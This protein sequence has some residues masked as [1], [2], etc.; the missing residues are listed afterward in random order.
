MGTKTTHLCDFFSRLVQCVEPHTHE[1]PG[2]HDV[3]G[4]DADGFY[5]VA[6]E[7]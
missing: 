4:H 1:A 2:Q 5:A 6:G 3:V 7:V